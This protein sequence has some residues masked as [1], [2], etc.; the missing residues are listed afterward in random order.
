MNKTLLSIFLVLVVGTTS[1]QDASDSI[2]S[3]EYYEIQIFSGPTINGTRVI[4][5]DNVGL[6][7]RISPVL[8]NG[9]S[10]S[11]VLLFNELTGKELKRTWNEIYNLRRFLAEY[12]HRYFMKLVD[13][14]NGYCCFESEDEKADY[15]VALGYPGTRILFI[16]QNYESYYIYY[17]YC[18]QKL[19]E[20]IV[21]INNII[22]E[23]IR[24]EFQISPRCQ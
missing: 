16:D 12:D 15:P 13:T 1:G 14:R 11:Q 17:E 3:F 6:T 22:P 10:S 5:L 21:L 4:K 7:L 23:N 8:N 18:N 9:K 20:L 19:D 24:E 2:Q